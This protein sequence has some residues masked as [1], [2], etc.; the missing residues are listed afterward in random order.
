MSA[1]CRNT[2]SSTIV[3]I[4]FGLA[5]NF[6]DELGK[7]IVRGRTTLFAGNFFFASVNAFRFITLSRRDDMISLLNILA[8]FFIGEVPWA[9]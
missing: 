3:L 7:H 9:D 4:D 5:R 1:D 8:Y 2:N 6:K